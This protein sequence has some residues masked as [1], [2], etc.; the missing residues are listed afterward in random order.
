MRCRLLLLFVLPLFLSGCQGQSRQMQAVADFRTQL[1]QSGG[2]GFQATV[3]AQYDNYANEFVLQCAYH[4]AD[5]TL[6]FSVLEPEPIAS[7]SGTVGQNRKTVSFDDAALELELLADGRVAPVALPQLIAQS[8]AKG[9]ILSAGQDREYTVAVFQ[10]GYEDDT[11]KI[12]TWFENGSPVY[13][14]VWYGEKCQAGI[15]L[16]SFYFQK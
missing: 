7:L 14:D 10:N 3:E 4:T 11:I 6:S 15:D 1:L 5:D 8:W 16:D 13:A 12:E 9:Y 2:C